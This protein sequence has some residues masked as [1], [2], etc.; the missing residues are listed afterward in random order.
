MLPVSA[1]LTF[2]RQL[3]V[4]ASLLKVQAMPSH[5]TNTDITGGFS[6]QTLVIISITGFTII[7]STLAFFYIKSPSDASGSGSNED[8]ANA[9]TYEEQLETADV[10]TLNRAQRRAR[11]KIL[12]KKSRRLPVVV[13]Q[14]PRNAEGQ[15][16][17]RDDENRLMIA[18]ENEALVA[19]RQEPQLSRKERQKL[20][21]VKEREERQV[22][23][24]ERR[25][26]ELE[27]QR[28]LE[29]DKARHLLE[30]EDMKK[31]ERELKIQ[32]WKFLFGQDGIKVHDF[33]KELKRSK[34][35]KLDETAERFSVK[36]ELLVD[37]L[38]Q[39][40][41]EGRINCGIVNDERGEYIYIGSE[42]M[43]KIAEWMMKTGSSS[44]K[45]IANEM[46]KIVMG[47]VDRQSEV[48]PDL[49]NV[50]IE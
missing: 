33:L 13:Q 15:E 5:G 29:I 20:A 1:V 40:E 39:L 42:D 34:I 46:S 48:K 27:K 12:M 30:L 32:N 23:Q 24:E 22:Y 3:V 18:L 50:T 31:K 2:Y 21:R 17:E 9:P 36:K 4:A 26:K 44:L 8:D 43:T 45:E 37:R 6:N 16:L 19:E 11:A 14:G 7:L 28:V 49:T 38:V 10:S 25:M 41:D 47:G 35:I